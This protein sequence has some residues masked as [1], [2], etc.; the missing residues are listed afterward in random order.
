M[1]ERKSITLNQAA[2]MVRD[3]NSELANCRIIDWESYGF[4]WDW[5]TYEFSIGDWVECEGHDELILDRNG[6]VLR[7]DGYYMRMDENGNWS[8]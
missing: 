6:N 2:Q 1:S 5:A 4:Y 7:Y 3:W 8:E